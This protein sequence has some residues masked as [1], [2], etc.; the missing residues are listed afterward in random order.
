[1]AQHLDS[2]CLLLPAPLVPGVP[3]KTRHKQRVNPMSLYDRHTPAY[4]KKPAHH[5][6]L[7]TPIMP[8]PV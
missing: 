1:M 2:R 5:G 7:A 6:V 8:R 4:G 3:T